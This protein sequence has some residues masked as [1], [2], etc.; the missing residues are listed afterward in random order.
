M[1]C[2][3][4][5]QL[6]TIAC[7]VLTAL[8]VAYAQAPDKLRTPAEATV[9]NPLT[10]LEIKALLL[11]FRGQS[12]T[13]ASWGGA[14]QAAQRR[15]YLEPFERQFG[16]TFV[17]DTN[18]LQPKIQAMVEA[19][20]VTIDVVDLG[21]RQSSD[22]ATRNGLETLDFRVIDR[23]RIPEI[24]RSEHSGGGGAV[25]A[26]VLAYRDGVRK[27]SSWAD[28]WDVKGF[29]GRRGFS[30]FLA[31][32]LEFPLLAAGISPKDITFP[33]TPAQEQIAFDKLKEI[34]PSVTL[35]WNSGSAPPE[36]LIK[37]EVDYTTAWNGRIFDAQKQGA[38][39]R[40]CWECGFVV[41]I[42][43]FSI[44]KGSPKK[45]LAQLFIAW[46][47]F[48]ENNVRLS[49]VSSYGPTDQ[50]AVKMLSNRVDRATLRELPGSEANRQ[51][52]VFEDGR[53]VGQNTE[54]LNP[55]YQALFQKR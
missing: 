15:A 53:W 38:P 23:R 19:K 6:S 1:R 48:P 5:F 43:A 49:Q 32:H 26:T 55:P 8:M 7:V 11:K 14:L 44:P 50:E 37:G 25:W 46:T 47:A 34:A 4:V 3:R 27:P 39:I 30:Q 10:R 16:I 28:F 35:F 9:D 45:E 17:E 21:L 12:L 20:N 51:W 18:P 52:A 54:R 24:W 42:D 33:L 41:G 22:L 13:F 40:V 36:L 29:P 31:G 2:R